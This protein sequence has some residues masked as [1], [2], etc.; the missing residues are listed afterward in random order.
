MNQAYVYIF[1]LPLEPLSHPRISPLQVITEHQAELPV[2]YSTFLLFIYF[3]YGS[4]YLS[5]TTLNLSF[6]HH[7]HKAIL[8]ACA[9]LPALQIGSSAPFL[10]ATC[11]C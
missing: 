8:Y 11:M 4:V 3:T 7:L 10:D 5:I 9:S 2:W 6:F 1:P